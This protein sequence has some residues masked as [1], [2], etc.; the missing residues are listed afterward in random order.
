[1]AP[2]AATEHR[3]GIDRK[4][5]VCLRLGSA[6]N[7]CRHF[8]TGGHQIMGRP[9][10]VIIVAK[11]HNFLTWRNP[12]PV[13][14]GA[15]RPRRHNSRSIIIR[16]GNTALQSARCQNRPFGNDTPE[17]FD[18]QILCGVLTAPWQPL[19]RA[20]GA[21]IISPG[22]RGS[23]HQSDIRQCCKFCHALCRPISPRLISNH[24][25]F[26]VQT[27]AHDAVFIGKDHIRPGPSCRQGC[28]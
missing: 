18:R 11:H 28:H 8:D 14:I 23:R 26:A 13:N 15:D 20:I 6:V 27:P 17:T 21:L 4:I 2:A 7:Q 10:G 9:M 1:M 5:A 12:P 25:R 24:Q 3:P 19:Q 22:H 16:K